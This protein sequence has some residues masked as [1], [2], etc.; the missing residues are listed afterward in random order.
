MS[1]DADILDRCR[2]ITAELMESDLEVV[3]HVKAKL[4]EQE[5][6]EAVAGLMRSYAHASRALRQSVALTEKLVRGEAREAREAAAE[7]RRAAILRM[8]PPPEPGRPFPRD[9][10]AADQRAA[11]LRTAV[12][13]V[14]WAEGF[15]ESEVRAERRLEGRCYRRL[16]DWIADERCEDDFVDRPLDEHVADYCEELD[17]NPDN[18]ARWRDLPEPEDDMIRA[19]LA[20]HTE[21]AGKP[22]WHETG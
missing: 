7:V 6:P 14:I 4:L 1:S 5:T 15:E 17:L 10:A 13:R 12:R 9:I 8:A 11:D 22:V 21:Y 20:N 18:A 2:Q 19:S 3:R 16:E